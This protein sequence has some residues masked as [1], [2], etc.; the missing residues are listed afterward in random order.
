MEEA[1]NYEREINKIKNFSFLTYLIVIVF[2][3]IF[4]L[5]LIA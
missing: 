3:G 4:V 2:I 1:M 5:S